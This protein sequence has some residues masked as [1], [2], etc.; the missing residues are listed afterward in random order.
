MLVTTVSDGK[1]Y[2]QMNL[3]AI[4]SSIS[5]L[6]YQLLACL[7]VYIISSLCTPPPLKAFLGL[8]NIEQ[9]INIVD[10]EFSTQ[11]GSAS[12]TDN[13]LGLI[14]FDSSQY[15][16]DTVYFEVIF[17]CVDCTGGGN[18]QVVAGLYDDQGNLVTNST[19]TSV[20]GTFT[21]SRSIAL[22]LSSDNYTVRFYRDDDAG[23]AYLKA[24]RLIIVQ[25]D[26]QLTDTQTQIEVGNYEN[27]TN[28]SA[29]PLTYPKYYSYDND[30]YSGTVN[31]YFEA[32][33][34]SDSNSTS[35]TY[36]FNSYDSGVNEW[37]TSPSLMTDNNTG[38]YASTS[39]DTDLHRLTANTNA[40]SDLGTITQVEVRIYSYQDNDTTGYITLTPFFGG[41]STGDNHNLTPPVSTGSWS[42]N[43]DITTDTNAPSP[44]SWSDIQNLDLDVIWNQ[45][46]GSN[47]GFASKVEIIVTY[48]DNTVL[49]YAQLYNRTN[50]TAVGNSTVS[51]YHS[52]PQ[53]VRSSALGSD[54]DTANDDEYEVRIYTN[55]A[56]NA[57]YLANAKIII[58]QTDTD[59]INNIEVIHQYLN[60]I[61]TQT[62]TDFTQESY[63]N[64]FA[65]YNFS[66]SNFLEILFEA[67]LKTSA[68]TGYAALYNYSDTDIIDTS[69]TSEVTTTSTSF[70]RKTSNNLTANSDWPSTAINFDTITKASSSETTSISSAW[71]II[72]AGAIDPDISLTIESVAASQTNNGV[73]ST[74]G[75]T[76][77]TIPFGNIGY[78]TPAYAT[79]KLTLQTNDATTAFSITMGLDSPLQGSYPANHFDPFIG[80]S[81]TWNDPKA[82]VTP[83][84]IIPNDNTGWIGA[85]TSDTDISGW[86]SGS[87]LFGPISTT[88][89]EI[90]YSNSGSGETV[91]VS[92]AIEANISQPADAYSAI[93]I[94]N[95]LPT[96]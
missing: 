83:T 38:N 92:Y 33:L 28:T 91:Y 24:A 72:Q 42:S 22:S 36:Y 90:A 23:T 84:G 27:S 60:T 80:S 89:V 70:E 67:T 95:V 52:S 29:A 11:A 34:H 79:H 55:N 3:S 64:Q 81:A 7:L 18:H 37:S 19:R 77:T 5:K 57:V 41:S 45:N 25:S 48:E 54:W 32:T 74:V 8:S 78:N 46:G 4:I 94:Y 40:G 66:G 1:T 49:A 56:A 10:G 73:T 82:W 39:S 21:I 35:Q 63:Y 62:N 2:N 50:T 12:P 43:V 61:Q 51:T 16:A 31:A 85:N 96:F 17:R 47:T 14:T 86:S 88:P 69:T 76:V 71:L 20:S 9:Q 15:T 68:S 26:P 30:Q 44:W 53:L 58:D 75:T 13:S 59:G 6:K 87:G 65:P 93:L